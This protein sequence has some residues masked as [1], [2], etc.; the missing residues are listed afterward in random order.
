MS[1]TDPRFGIWAI[2][3][4]GW[5]TNRHPEDPFD[6]SFERNKRVLQLAEELGYDATLV[7][8]HTINPLGDDRAQL[9]AWT[10]SAALA[11]VTEKIEIITAI[12]PYLYHPVVLAK[13]ALQIE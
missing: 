1:T 8:Q 13:Q 6:P 10:G 9:E 5:A 11:A 3:H 7:A 2:V 12:K 4:G